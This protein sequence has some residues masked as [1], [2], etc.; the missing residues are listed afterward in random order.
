MV[1]LSCIGR[2]FTLCCSSSKKKQVRKEVDI[3]EFGVPGTTGTYEL[4]KMLYIL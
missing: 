4:P 1:D 3:G 2:S